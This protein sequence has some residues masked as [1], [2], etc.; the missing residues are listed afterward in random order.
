MKKDRSMN[1]PANDLD[2]PLPMMGDDT[3]LAV[4][5]RWSRA[6]ARGA[7]KAMR[8]AANDHRVRGF[9]GDHAK[10]QIAGVMFGGSILGAIAARVAT[11]SVPGAMLVAS[12][13]VAKA[14]HD[15]RKRKRTERRREKA[16]TGQEEQ[17][18]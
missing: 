14:V 1:K 2:T 15:H 5:A 12:A 13:L 3:R 4:P 7:S 18:G 6:A 16:A 11:R 10:K 9:I 8:G 17:S